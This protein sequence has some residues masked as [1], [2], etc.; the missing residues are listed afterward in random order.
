M[1]TGSERIDAKRFSALIEPHFDRLF[2]LAYRL[3]G[4][5]SDAEDLIQDVM[6][7]LYEQRESLATVA[8]L[9]PWLS[10]V[11]FNRFVDTRR[12]SNRRPLTL[13]GDGSLEETESEARTPYGHSGDQP[14]AQAIAAEN[15]GRLERALTRLSEDQ[16]SLLL[17]HDAEGFTLPEIEAMTETPLGTLKS[18]LSRA[19]ARLRELLW[20][21]SEITDSTAEE[22]NMEPF[23]TDQRVGG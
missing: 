3:T 15:T 14:E 6:V 20:D 18:R 22:K 13:V 10:R 5:R 7:R 1:P 19:R 23:S 21:M 9:K 17:M 4:A 12:A 8:D 2:R 16:R 11:L